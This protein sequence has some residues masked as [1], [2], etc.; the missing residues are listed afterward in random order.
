MVM[1]GPGVSAQCLEEAGEKRL[2]SFFMPV[3][4]CLPSWEMNLDFFFFKW[5][6]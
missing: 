1:E 6:R 4:F 5:V 3:S 2:I